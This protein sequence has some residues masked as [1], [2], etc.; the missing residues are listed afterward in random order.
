[1]SHL[2]S[3][4]ARALGICGFTSQT[5][6]PLGGLGAAAMDSDS[7]VA[8]ITTC[9]PPKWQRGL[10]PSSRRRLCQLDKE[11]NVLERSGSEPVKRHQPDKRP[12]VKSSHSSLQTVSERSRM[13]PGTQTRLMCRSVAARSRVAWRTLLQITRLKLYG[14]K[15]C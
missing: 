10:K 3:S 11:S 5:K 7:A 8:R 14:A 1:M 6:L 12:K 9:R 2:L 13:P 4:S 15:P